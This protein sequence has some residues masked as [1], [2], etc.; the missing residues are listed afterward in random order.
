M[1]K[2]KNTA[3]GNE[4]M[5]NENR[6]ENET[7]F[8]ANLILI[9]LLL[10]TTAFSGCEWKFAKTEE[11]S[12]ATTTSPTSTTSTTEDPLDEPLLNPPLG[13]RTFDYGDDFTAEDIEF[14]RSLHNSYIGPSGDH[15]LFSFESTISEA[16]RFKTPIYY[17]S[18]DTENPYFI[19]AFANS[20][21]LF[22]LG[23]PVAFMD[24]TKYSWH[25]FYDVDS[26]PES[27]E[28]KDLQHKY[29]LYDCTIKKDI[30]NG[31]DYDYHCKYYL[32]RKTLLLDNSYKNVL[33]YFPGDE[34]VIE[35]KTTFLLHKTSENANFTLYV[36]KDEKVYLHLYDKFLLDGKENEYGTAREILGEY[37]DVLSPYFVRLPELDSEGINDYGQEYVVRYVGISLNNLSQALFE[38]K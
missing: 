10:T 35:D 5:K 21:V 36:G 19:C 38:N 18:I 2:A 6:K 25:K 37:Y 8:L 29:L 31:I 34:V 11:S 7:K 13:D 9:A 20:K 26:I 1:K 22:E 24:V 30:V 17:A 27:I 32:S 15:T 33:I 12:T 4:T 23:G 14:V 16:Q 3:K 28:D